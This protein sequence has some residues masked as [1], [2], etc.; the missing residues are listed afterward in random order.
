MRSI[1]STR[2]CGTYEIHF[3]LRYGKL[4][5]IPS[6]IPGGTPGGLLTRGVQYL[7]TEF[8]RREE[9]ARRIVFNLYF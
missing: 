3:D 4:F 9:V 7:G 1:G 2:Y 8:L 5:G 6:G